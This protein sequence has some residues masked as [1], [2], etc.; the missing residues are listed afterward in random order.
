MKQLSAIVLS[1][2]F[3][4]P[5]IGVDIDLTHCCGDL[6]EVGITH[7]LNLTVTDCCDMEQ[8]ADCMESTEL[9]QP[10]VQLTFSTASEVQIPLDYSLI[11]FTAFN[12]F[13][14]EKKNQSQPIE[15]TDK[16]LRKAPPLSLLQ[17]FLC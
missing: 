16:R 7:Q 17:V 13:S 2:L 12:P 14:Q 5:T 9:K 6:Q 8:D 4:L 15:A 10:P 3:L 11:I 1:L